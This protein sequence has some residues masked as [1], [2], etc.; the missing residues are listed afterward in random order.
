MKYKIDIQHLLPPNK[1]GSKNNAVAFLIC[2]T[3]A[4]AFEKFSELSQKLLKINQWKLYARKNPTEFYLHQK[5]NEKSAIAQL[6]DFV[7]IKMPAPKNQSGK[8]FDWVM[9]NDMQSIDQ[10]ELKV[11]LLQM[12]PHSCPISSKK[13]VAHF[14]TEAASNTF[15]LAQKDKIIQM[16]IHGRNEIPNTKKLGLINSLRNF[17]VASGGIFGGSKVQWQDFTEEFIKN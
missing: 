8:G 3:E 14:Y 6:K 17:F 2:D 5:E 1:D 9:V 10:P 12:K 4:K 13:N 11:F 16:S 15:V 7:K